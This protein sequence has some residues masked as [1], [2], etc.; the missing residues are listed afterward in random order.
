MSV[1]TAELSTVA[2][3]PP[4]LPS[5]A[6]AAARPGSGGSRCGGCPSLSPCAG[7]HPLRGRRPRN[8]GTEADGATGERP[9]RGGGEISVDVYKGRLGTGVRTLGTV[10]AL[11][12][13]GATH[14]NAL[15]GGIG[16]QDGSWQKAGWYT[17]ILT[18]ASNAEAIAE[19]ERG[20]GW[21]DAVEDPVGGVVRQ[22]RGPGPPP[23]AMDTH[24]APPPPHNPHQGSF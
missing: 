16:A 22:Q 1:N 3:A 23:Q 18:M 9:H 10:G 17:P 21:E 11:G 12:I 4:P 24:P 7:P 2:S 8:A 14:C 15:G 13:D 20:C 6:A 5:L 19:G